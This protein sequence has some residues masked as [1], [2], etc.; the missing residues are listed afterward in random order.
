M[1]MSRAG[2]S[3]GL[4][5]AVDTFRQ[6]SGILTRGENADV[7]VDW[8]PLYHKLT[9]ANGGTTL[10][11][12]FK[13]SVTDPDVGNY[14]GPGQLDNS[15]VV[16][17]LGMGFDLA[18]IGDDELAADAGALALS[19]AMQK[20]IRGGGIEFWSGQKKLW[21]DRGLF[22]YPAGGGVHT[23][24]AVATTATTTTD[25]VAVT[26]NGFPDIRNFAWFP[27][28][29]DIFPKDKL[30]VVVNYPS[31]IALPSGVTL[32]IQCTLRCQIITD[33]EN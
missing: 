19:L 12:F 4:S 1:N 15:G 14:A 29:F 23:Q 32:D 22:K 5:P 13:A 25:A 9:G 21:S 3:Q 2:A 20:Y 17:V 30:K 6:T 31:A 33:A 16:R 10:F 26:N 24:A 11:E 18:P 28:P 7:R 8:F 27:A